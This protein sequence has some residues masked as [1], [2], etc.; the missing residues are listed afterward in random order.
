MY[1]CVCVCVCMCVCTYIHV[2]A[3]R[4]IY[5]KLRLAST[6][7]LCMKLSRG[8]Q[9]HQETPKSQKIGD[10]FATWPLPRYRRSRPIAD[11]VALCSR[12]R[13]ACAGEYIGMN[14]H[15]DDTRTPARTSQGRPK[16]S[17]TW[18]IGVSNALQCD[19][20]THLPRAL[21][22]PGRSGARGSSRRTRSPPAPQ[23][24]GACRGQE[25]ARSSRQRRGGLASAET[26]RRHG[27]CGA[28]RSRSRRRRAP[29][30]RVRACVSACQ[31]ARERGEG[32]ASERERER[33]C[34]SIDAS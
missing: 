28:L 33:V 30:L 9:R 3:C 11:D 4:Y 8:P 13:P 1:M 27:A 34:V 12:T 15:R 17:A 31:R 5:I 32:R 23:S 10:T 21:R 6:A 20:R 18:H 14:A 22:P 29:R 2:R 24:P 7:A 26:L 19:M 25:L 16:G